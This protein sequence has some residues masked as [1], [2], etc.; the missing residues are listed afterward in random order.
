MA[1][2]ES[3]V[4]IRVTVE[5]PAT[6]SSAASSLVKAVGQFIGAIAA[7]AGAIYLVGTLVL[8][9]RLWWTAGISGVQQVPQLAR[10]VLVSLG[11]EVILIP[12]GIGAGY[13]VYRVVVRKPE[14]AP[15]TS[16]A[17]VKAGNAVAVFLLTATPA[18]AAWIYAVLSGHGEL[19]SGSL[20][21]DIVVE[22]V[23]GAALA[24]IAL[25]LTLLTLRSWEWIGNGYVK[26]AGRTQPGVEYQDPERIAAEKW[27]SA[28]AIV[29]VALVLAAASVPSWAFAAMSVPLG[30]ATVCPKSGGPVSGYLVGEGGSRT[31]LA[32][33]DRHVIVSF[34]SDQVLRVFAGHRRDQPP[35]PPPPAAGSS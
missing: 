27:N 20:V 10:D 31:Y 12:L 11:L 15:P 17:K 16:E 22:C 34:P 1:S 4:P 13:A 6:D 21:L 33:Y 29:V 18:V 23:I 5:P 19:H 28:G 24:G 8:L 3:A 14:E 2:E 32:P 30:H 26:E 7:V 35:C 25:C 9:A